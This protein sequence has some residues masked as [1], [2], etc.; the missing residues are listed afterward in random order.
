MKKMNEIIEE[1]SSGKTTLESANA[2]LKSAGAGFHLD[3]ERNK[4]APDEVGR[5]GLLDTGTGTLDKVKIVDFD[6]DATQRSG[7]GGRGGK[8]ERGEEAAKPVSSGAKY[9]ATM[10]CGEM[11]AYCFVGGVCYKVKGRELVEE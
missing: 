6:P 8:T 7:C 4:I 11:T 9:L 1:Y 5:Y 10:D 2:A 3:P